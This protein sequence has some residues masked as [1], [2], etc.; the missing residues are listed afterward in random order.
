MTA[1]IV[2]LAQALSVHLLPALSSV[3]PY[4]VMTA[5]LLVKPYGLFGTPQVRRI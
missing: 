3:M 1:V 5:I 2:G 4:L